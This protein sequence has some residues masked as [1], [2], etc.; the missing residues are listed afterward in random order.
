[1]NLSLF[2]DPFLYYCKSDAEQRAILKDL[3]DAATYAQ[4]RGVVIVAAAGNESD[5]LGHP[6]IDDTSPAGRRTRT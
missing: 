3:Q 2:A 5:D 4:Q 1:V 6:I